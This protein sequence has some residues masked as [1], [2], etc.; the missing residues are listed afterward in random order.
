VRLRFSSNQ[1]Q[2]QRPLSLLPGDVLVD[3]LAAQLRKLPVLSTAF[4]TR[5][6]MLPKSWSSLVASSVGFDTGDDKE[7]E[8]EKD[9]SPP[10]L[11]KGD[12][13]LVI[14][15]R[16]TMPL[17]L[18]SCAADVNRVCKSGFAVPAQLSRIDCVLGKTSSS[19]VIKYPRKTLDTL[20]L[21]ASHVELNKAKHVDYA[22][23]EFTCSDAK[24]RPVWLSAAAAATAASPNNNSNDSEKKQ[25]NTKT[26]VVLT[27]AAQ[28]AAHRLEQRIAQQYEY[29]FDEGELD[30]LEMQSER[31]LPSD[32]AKLDALLEQM[33]TADEHATTVAMDSAQKKRVL[34]RKMREQRKLGLSIVPSFFGSSSNQEGTRVLLVEP[35]APHRLLGVAVVTNILAVTH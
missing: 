3:P 32:S 22:S 12:K 34:L 28:L 25:N 13:V 11:S 26:K 35:T 19:S 2:Q 5:L 10:T 29:L 4:R 27:A 24:N 9:S 18:I 15:L 8:E 30:E 7:D 16:G 17:A 33:L 14:A 21:R 6:L 20:K 23:V 31:R 1:Q